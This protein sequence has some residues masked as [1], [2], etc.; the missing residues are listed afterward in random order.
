MEYLD[1]Y[2]H[3]RRHGE[4]GVIPPAELEANYDRQTSPTDTAEVTN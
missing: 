4:I 3:R 1:W 2:N